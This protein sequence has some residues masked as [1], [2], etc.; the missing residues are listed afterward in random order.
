ME[1]FYGNLYQWLDGLY[2]TYY[3]IKTDYRNSVFTGNNGN[4]FQF[5]TS[6]NIPDTYY[7]N[8][9]EILGTNNSGFVM[10]TG[11]D[12]NKG[13]NYYCDLCRLNSNY[14]SLSGGRKRE[15]SNA[16]V[17]YLDVYY[18]ASETNTSIGARLMYKHKK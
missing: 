3:S 17:F 5:N 4:N 10:K 7:Y 6:C 9:Q 14:F 11:T 2:A 1:D 18:G 15:G 12:S 8:I 13:Q 16:G